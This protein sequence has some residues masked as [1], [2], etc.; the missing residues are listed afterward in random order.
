MWGMSL[1]S[2]LLTCF[3]MEQTLFNDYESRLKLDPEL[4]AMRQEFERYKEGLRKKLIA[5]YK[6]KPPSLIQAPKPV[7][8]RP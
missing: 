4:M 8:Y 1:F 6:L 2:L 5:R 3:I 7:I